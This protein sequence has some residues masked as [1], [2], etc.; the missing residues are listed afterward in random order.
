VQ[1]LGLCN[2]QPASTRAAAKAFGIPRTYEQWEDLVA[3]PQIDAVLIG[4][5]PYLHGP[6]AIAALAAGKY[7]LSEARMAMEFEAIRGA[8]SPG[9]PDFA[10][11][12][13]YMEFTEAVAR[14]AA[15]RKA[16]ALPLDRASSYSRQ[17]R[18]ACAHGAKC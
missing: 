18:R 16:V 17:T 15:V 13:R 10:F 3:D 5:W 4:T 11:G 8:A 7:V 1:I 12:L 2:R 9:L 14:S 6:I